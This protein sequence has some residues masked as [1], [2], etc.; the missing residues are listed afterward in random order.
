MRRLERS[1]RSPAGSPKGGR[2]GD[3]Q[4]Y[5]RY[6]RFPHPIERSIRPGEAASS[7]CE[8]GND[9]ACGRDGQIGV[10]GGRPGGIA[11]L[12]SLNPRLPAGTPPA[13]KCVD[14]Q[15]GKRL[16]RGLLF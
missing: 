14:L 16:H 3:R 6:P 1:E 5:E 2:G 9:A 4:F 8:T 13:T 7:L 11:R 12:G 15:S 10:E